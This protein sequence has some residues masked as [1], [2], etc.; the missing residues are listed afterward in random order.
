MYLACSPHLSTR[1][2]E[3]LNAQLLPVEMIVHKFSLLS[4]LVFLSR[5]HREFGRVH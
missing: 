5:M 2:N 3:D 1:V 4:D